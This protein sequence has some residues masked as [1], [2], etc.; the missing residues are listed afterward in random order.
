MQLVE[1]IVGHCRHSRLRAHRLARGWTLTRLVSE[2]V[3]VAGVGHRLVSSRVSRWER[4]EEQP[5]AVYRD[6]LCRVYRTGPVDLGLSTDYGSTTRAPTPEIT[7]DTSTSTSA[8]TGVS[9]AG[10]DAD[11][12]RLPRQREASGVDAD[13]GDVVLRRADT[14]RRR[15][16][17]TLSAST[18][19]DAT[20]AYKE[21]VA[22]QYGRTYKTEPA[23]RFLRNILADLDDVR[24]ITDRKLPSSHRR[25]L[26]AVTARL[27]GLVSMTMVN[28]GLYRQAREW[29]H[30]AR[31]AADEAEDP[32]LR[33]WV[34][35][36]GAVASLHLG[37][38]HA[39]AAAAREAEILTRHQPEPI[40]AM[41]WA[42]LA[43]A[44]AIMVQPTAAR[45]ALH[46]AEAVFGRTENIADNSAYA[47]TT[48]QL[49]FYTSH[50]LTTIG[51]TRAARQAQDDALAAFG[52]GEH[53]DPTLVHLDR[54]LCM[55]TDGD[56]AVGV[57]YAATVLLRLP[58]EY[59]PTIVIRRARAVA[60][61]VP[62]S[63]RTLPAVRA[64]HDALAIDAGPTG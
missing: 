41:A 62:P 50:A 64:L 2:M 44:A 15:V 61:A 36:R 58:V 47:F 51:E 1:A 25:D 38:P 40:T 20:V 18:L 42:I 57:D 43:R 3:T 45:T 23:G 21:S 55:V 24:V 27:A 59:R 26:C 39:A 31:L 7:P 34:A 30:T 60:A 17:E 14:L 49:H 10:G 46:H 28:L 11:V 22:Q 33:A 29:V 5:S 63:R 9:R 4:D 56:V 13:G 8:G 19:S 35:T 12:W 32:H 48:G 52:P 6:A 37:D 53:L 16:D 54:A